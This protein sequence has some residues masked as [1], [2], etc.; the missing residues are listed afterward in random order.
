MTSLID[1]GIIM[2]LES[3]RKKKYTVNFDKLELAQELINSPAN[4]IENDSII[5]P[6]MPEP[7]GYIYWFDN[8][9][10]RKFKNQS[11]YR[12]FF[13][14]TD[15]MSFATQLITGMTNRKASNHIYGIV[16]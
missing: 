12:I 8:T 6:Y 3:Q 2:S 5:Q 14:K 9:E 15:K 10:N 1:Q 13:K 7:E 16:E 11:T 4:I